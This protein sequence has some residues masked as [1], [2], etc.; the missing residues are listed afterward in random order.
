MNQQQHSGPGSREL[1]QFGLVF[2]LMLTGV[3]ILLV[4]WL[5]G[6]ALPVWPWLPIS[7]FLLSAA[8][9]PYVLRPVYRAWMKLAVILNVVMSRVLLGIVYYLVVTPMGIAMRLL[10]KDP[11]ALRWVTSLQSYRIPS[12]PS[13][14]N[15]MERPF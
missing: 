11:L 7:F 9:F 5:K 4:P 15:D 8:F 1:R 2:G 12:R 14:A 10:G 13:A 3:F 6:T